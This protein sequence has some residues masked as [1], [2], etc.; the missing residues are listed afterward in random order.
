MSGFAS[1]FGVQDAI[2]KAIQDYNST[3]AENRL[4]TI[5]RLPFQFLDK[6]VS[7]LLVM[8]PFA[9]LFFSGQAAIESERLQ[10]AASTIREIR[11]MLFLGARKVTANPYDD[12]ERVVLGHLD[13]IRESLDGVELTAVGSQDSF[14]VYWKSDAIAYGDTDG[15]VYGQEFAISK[16]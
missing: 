4:K 16:M 6:K 8:E 13:G 12:A 9:L 15:V 7:D 11:L 1:T 3:L 5:K 2:V 10:S 14:N